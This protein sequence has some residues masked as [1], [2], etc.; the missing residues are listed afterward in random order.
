M[1]GLTPRG[2]T[3]VELLV[4]LTLTGLLAGA[5][6]GLLAHT[7]DFYRVAAQAIDVSQSLRVAGAVLPAELRELDAIDG[8][9]VAMSPTAVTVRAVRQ[10]AVLCRLPLPDELSGSVSLSLRA[11][12][13]QLRPLDPTT[14]SLWVFREGDPLSPEDDEWIEAAV[15]DLTPESCPDGTTGERVTAVPRL[16]P[17]QT[18][19]AGPV[20]VGA[21]VLGFETVTYRLYRSSADRRWYVGLETAADL[22]PVLGPVTEDGL[23]FSYLDSSGAA[24]ARATDIRVIELR[25]RARTMEPVRTRDGSLE[26]PLD[27][28]VTAVYLRNNPRL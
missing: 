3:L 28:L 18:M 17:G 12:F 7:R 24:A 25:V 20:T 26:R 8:D 4:A 15:T 2:V 27:S 11:P 10:L 21:P 23:A 22:Q 6:A 19:S 14:D 5:A 1:R 9:V 13:S 16:A